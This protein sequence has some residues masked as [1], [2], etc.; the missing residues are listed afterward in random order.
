MPLLGAANTYINPHG[1]RRMTRMVLDAVAELEGKF[2]E[3]RAN[4]QNTQFDILIL[5]FLAQA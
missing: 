5:K 4:I 2:K 3:G 1:A